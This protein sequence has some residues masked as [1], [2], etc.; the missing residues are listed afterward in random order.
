MRLPTG[1]GAHL[2]DPR[3]CGALEQ[4]DKL[5]A[6][7]SPKETPRVRVSGVIHAGTTISIDLRTVHFD[8]ELKGP[9]S[10]ERREVENVT[11]FVAVN[12][13]SGSINVLPSMEISGEALLE[14]IGMEEKEPEG[15]EKSNEPAKADG[16]KSKPQK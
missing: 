11:E 16:D 8:K 14:S 7:G 9:I 1:F 10:I 5:L 6:D 3:A 15:N 4:R 2:R 13:L 12:Q